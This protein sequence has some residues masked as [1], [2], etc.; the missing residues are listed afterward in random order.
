MLTMA[1]ERTA[2]RYAGQLRSQA[3]Y[4]ARHG[5]RHIVDPANRSKI[6]MLKRLPP[7]FLKLAAITR[8]LEPGAGCR[9]LLWFDADI[10]FANQSLSVARWLRP[11]P[12]GEALPL[13]ILTDHHAALNNGAIFLNNN[14]SGWVRETFMTL[15]VS[16]AFGARFQH[17]NWPATDNGAMVE[18]VLQLFV[19]EY[20]PLRCM[21]TSEPGRFFP[22]A[23]TQLDHAFG[24]ADHEWSNRGGRGGGGLWLVAAPLGFNS[25]GCGP[26]GSKA[27]SAECAALNRTRVAKYGWAETDL[28]VPRMFGWHTKDLSTASADGLLQNTACVAAG[29]VGQALLAGTTSNRTRA[30]T[31]TRSRQP[32]VEQARGGLVSDKMVVDLKSVAAAMSGEGLAAQLALWFS[33]AAAMAIMLRVARHAA[34][35]V[36]GIVW[37][38][39]GCARC[40]LVAKQSAGRRESQLEPARRCLGAIPVGGRG[41]R[42]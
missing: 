9:W 21:N 41:I 26:A 31:G 33:C 2:R 8:W 27:A 4:A 20:R 42:S 6:A 25:H 23:H 15:W 29:G 12:P 19:P 7:S 32:S 18:A 5:L 34:A 38:Q 22:C 24:P 28:F 36:V 16:L 14:E 37:R 3:C 17:I 11:T 1:E 40:T 10:Y 35:R 30:R 39:F 13:L